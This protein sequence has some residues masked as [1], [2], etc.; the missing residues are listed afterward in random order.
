MS[1]GTSRNRSNRQ[2]RLPL[3]PYANIRPR[4]IPSLEALEPP[5]L[6]FRL[7]NP[8]ALLQAPHIRLDVVT[9]LATSQK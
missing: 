3:H 2:P 9:L 4:Q 7:G 6:S 1:D 5:Q 8:E